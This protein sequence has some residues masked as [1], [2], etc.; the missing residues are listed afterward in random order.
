ML[1]CKSAKT[2]KLKKGKSK[3]AQAIRLKAFNSQKTKD[4]SNKS[5]VDVRLIL[6]DVKG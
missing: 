3:K 2:K 4:T 6:L 5:A 1:E